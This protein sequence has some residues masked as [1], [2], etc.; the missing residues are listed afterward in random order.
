MIAGTYLASGVM[1]AV[2]AWL[3][4][5]GTLT[6]FTQTVAWVVIFFLA[7]AGASAAYL[8][9]SEIFPME[10]RGSGHCVF[11]RRGHRPRRDHRPRPFRPAHRHEATGRCGRR[12]CD[13]RLPNGGSRP[14]RGVPGYRRRT[15]EPGGHRAT[16]VGGGAGNGR[17]AAWGRAATGAPEPGGAIPTPTAARG[18]G[19]VVA[20]APGVDVPRCDPYLAREVDAIVDALTQE[21]SLSA[22]ELSRA[23]GARFWGGPVPC[24]R[25]VCTG[26]R[27]GPAG[28]AQPFRRRLPARC[29]FGGREW[30]PGISARGKRY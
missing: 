1:L 18:S 5:Q 3:F 10:T 26:V 8:T 29:Q 12:I 28:G 2:T 27:T 14:G 9:V 21:G 24:C 19:G 11:L 6:A 7:S 13:R 25:T 16:V 15:T 30:P 4:D 17:R 23:V 20:A 22:L